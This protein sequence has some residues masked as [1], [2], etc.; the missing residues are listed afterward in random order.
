VHLSASVQAAVDMAKILYHGDH[1]R[2][3][4]DALA[5]R[6]CDVTSESSR[7]LPAAC[8][9]LTTGTQHAGAACAL[10]PEC[11]SEFCAVPACSDACCQGTCTGDAAP[12]RGA[13]GA[14]CE[15][16]LCDDQTF[17]D[18]DTLMC[19]A[20]QPAHAFCSSAEECAYG[21]D[22]LPDGTCGALPALGSPCDTACSAAGTTCDQTTGTCV[23]VALAGGAC[24][25]DLGCS[26][27][28]ACDATGHCSAG[29]AIGATC[30]FGELCAGSGA[31]CDVA[32]GAATGT[33]VLPKPNGQ[34]CTRNADCSSAFCDPASLACADETV[35]L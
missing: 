32:D 6:S 9:E 14:S 31:F 33:C 28:Y 20:L 22:C 26:V 12:V 17:C 3:C 5:D 29:L 13:A 8:Y 7:A 16:V 19:V 2:T 25:G 18:L 10:D 30:T 11:I 4:F 1:A 27:F 34:S 23:K 15:T 21:L 24:T 35:C